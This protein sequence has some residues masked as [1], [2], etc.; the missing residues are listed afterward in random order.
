MIPTLEEIHRSLAGS[1]QLFMGRAE[2][3]RAF[4]VSIDGF[5]RSFGVIVLLCVPYA[6]TVVAEQRII[7]EE[8]T[9]VLGDFSQQAYVLAKAIGF[10]LDWV[11]YPVLVALLARPLAISAHYVPYIVARNWT[12][13][14]AILPYVVPALLY[15]FGLISA[16]TTMFLTLV[17]IGFVLRYRYVVA[18][19]AL[20]APVGL[21]IGLV[22]LDTVLSF[23]IGTAVNRAI[24][25]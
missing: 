22:V 5:W 4:D 17:A 2:G 19:I 16:T 24:G 13:A 25:I 10:V 9:L 6:I 15:N 7:D 20:H 18:R 8:A 23:V 14:I 21:A 3:M 1:W 12:S 11:C